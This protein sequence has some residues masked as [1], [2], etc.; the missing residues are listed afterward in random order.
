MSNSSSNPNDNG[1]CSTIEAAR[2]LGM[3]VRSVQLM[4]DRGDLKAWKTPGGHRRISRASVQT[5]LKTREVHPANQV[6]SQTNDG[7]HLPQ[8]SPTILVLDTDSNSRDDFSSLFKENFSSVQLHLSSDPIL[9]L[10]ML[11]F[12]KPNI[13]LF[14]VPLKGIN[15]ANLIEILKD[16]PDFSQYQLITYL[17]NE[18]SPPELQGLKQLGVSLV[19]APDLKPHIE[20]LLKS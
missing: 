7:A 15:A 3:A 11:D 6:F 2:I 10:T 14:S 9:A 12:I 20:S 18:V 13:I 16:K 1:Q 5:W 4:V 8:S 19:S 17:R